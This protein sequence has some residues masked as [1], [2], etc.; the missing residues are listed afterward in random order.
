MGNFDFNFRR[1]PPDRRWRDEMKIDVN[2][3][4][5]EH[6]SNYNRATRVFFLFNEARTVYVYNGR[7]KKEY[8]FLSLELKLCATRMQ[9]ILSVFVHIVDAVF[10]LC[11]KL[12]HNNCFRF[13]TKRVGRIAVCLDI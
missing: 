4:E 2:S 5:M 12:R 13:I 6:S 11:I 10:I 3:H 1:K 7:Q 9:Y 8:L